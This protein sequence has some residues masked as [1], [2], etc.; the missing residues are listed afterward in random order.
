MKDI[1]G[2]RD[3]RR[4]NIKKV[5]V[6]NISYPIT[7][8]DKARKTQKTVALIN[9]YVNLPHQFKGTHM[10]RFVEILNRF[11]GEI[12]LKS[13]HRILEEM[14]IRLQAEAAH[15][16]ITFP[17]FLKKSSGQTQSVGINEYRCTMHGSL[18]KTDD[19]ILEIKVPISPP[20]PPQI[21]QALP[22]SLGHWGI[23]TISLRFKHFLW[24]EDIV[25]LVEEVT[26]H[27]LCWPVTEACLEYTLS[28]ENLSTALGRKLE[29]HPAIAWFSVLVE[30]LSQG[31]NT[32]ASLEWQDPI[33][34]ALS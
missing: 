1:Q 25:Q 6:K 33:T 22:R 28:V 21:D 9:M 4:I 14:K 17:Y 5:G 27:D 23:A 20:L 24:I 3:Y 30:N 16:E 29:N 7:V 31:Y 18:D 15:M 26:S 12:N 2:Q 19:L 32:F 13:F 10:S 34:T 8:L 11:H